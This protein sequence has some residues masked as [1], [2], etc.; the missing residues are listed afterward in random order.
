MWAEL[1]S[2]S[3][4]ELGAVLFGFACCVGVALGSCIY[5]VFST[6][7]V[8]GKENDRERRSERSDRSA[9]TRDS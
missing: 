2:M 6:F 9:R 3:G 4:V 5:C 7:K 1:D 8:K